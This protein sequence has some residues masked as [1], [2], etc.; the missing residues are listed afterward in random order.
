MSRHSRHL[1]VLVVEDD[2]AFRE[3]VAL[4]LEHLGMEA[5]TVESVPDAIA[6]LEE[7]RVDAVLSDFS[8]P[9][10]DGL[11]LLAYIHAALPLTP[12]VLM[13]AS[14]DADVRTRALAAGAEAVYE[15]RELLPVLPQVFERFPAAA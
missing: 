6:T 1:H 15:K 5:T 8:L 10:P 7:V 9:G 13:S 4:R 11:S 3:L 12:F 14:L 2:P